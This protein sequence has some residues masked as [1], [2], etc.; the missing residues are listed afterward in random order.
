MLKYGEKY[1]PALLIFFT[2]KRGKKKSSRRL[3]GL[4]AQ[5]STVILE[6][7]FSASPSK[8]DSIFFYRQTKDIRAR[9]QKNREGSRQDIRRCRLNQDACSQRQFSRLFPLLC[10]CFFAR[11]LYH[12]INNALCGISPAHPRLILC[13]LPR[14]FQAGAV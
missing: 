14:G 9:R 8:N 7:Y 10:I 12:K 5:S 11:G 4:T 3:K 1:A 2:R 13:F 6:A